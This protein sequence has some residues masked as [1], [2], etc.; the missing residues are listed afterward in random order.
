MIKKQQRELFKV[1]FDLPEIIQGNYEKD[2]RQLKTAYEK[3][4]N[5]Y[6]YADFKTYKIITRKILKLQ[7]V[8]SDEAIIRK[9]RNLQGECDRK[10][11]RQ[12]YMADEDFFNAVDMSYCMHKDD[13]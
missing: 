4:V 9:L 12:K 1:L 2:V 10:R 6:Y 3:V 8:I 11:I 5:Q 7:N 13:Y